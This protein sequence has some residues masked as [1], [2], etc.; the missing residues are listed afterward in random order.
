M[1]QPYEA[2]EV[3]IRRALEALGGSAD[4]VADTLLKLGIRGARATFRTCPVA[5]YL[6][7]LAY[8]G[9][10]THVVADVRVLD[11]YVDVWFGAASQPERAGL[12]EPVR[13]F[14]H[15]FDQSDRYVELV[16]TP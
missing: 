8:G 1:N 16:V 13:E 4:E 6:H 5:E 14:V 9:E 3:G 2:D 12:P 11:T 7:H 15:R 10:F